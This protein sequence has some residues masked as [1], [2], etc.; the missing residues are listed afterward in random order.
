[1]Y[2][3]FGGG[4]ATIGLTG[5]TVLP[6]KGS[7]RFMFIVSMLALALGLVILVASSYVAHQDHPTADLKKTKK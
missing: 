4:F 7:S 1:M 5:A 3:G 2:Q 6:H